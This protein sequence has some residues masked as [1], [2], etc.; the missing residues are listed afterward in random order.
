MHKINAC[1]VIERGQQIYSSQELIPERMLR[2]PSLLENPSHMWDLR[3]R[4]A[5]RFEWERDL[6]SLLWGEKNTTYLFLKGQWYFT[7]VALNLKGRRGRR[8]EA[9]QQT[10][11]FSSSPSAQSFVSLHF[12]FLMKRTRDKWLEKLERSFLCYFPAEEESVL[13]IPFRI[14]PVKW[15]PCYTRNTAC[16]P[17][18]LWIPWRDTMWI[19]WRDVMG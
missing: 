10:K 9:T 14:Q 2:S 8:I 12:Y 6:F 4:R 11:H 5:V 19:S 16:I 15:T 7:H 17:Q 18:R 13:P 3:A 1:L